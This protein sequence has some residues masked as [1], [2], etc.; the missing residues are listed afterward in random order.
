MKYYS[1]N[2][3]IYKNQIEE[4]IGKGISTD[5]E[6]SISEILYTDENIQNIPLHKF[7]SDFYKELENYK[8]SG[9]IKFVS[10]K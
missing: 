4:L 3:S 1:E 8:V 9:E 10:N 2:S 5:L 7:E 6:F